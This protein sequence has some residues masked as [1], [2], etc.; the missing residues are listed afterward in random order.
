MGKSETLKRHGIDQF[1]DW[2][3]DLGFFAMWG[4][5]D[6]YEDGKEADDEWIEWVAEAACKTEEI[7]KLVCEAYADEETK[8]KVGTR[9]DVDFR[10]FL[11][12]IREDG[13]IAVFDADDPEE[14]LAI[15]FGTGKSIVRH[16]EEQGKAAIL[17]EPLEEGKTAEATAPDGNGTEGPETE[18]DERIETEFEEFVIW[19][20][21]MSHFVVVRDEEDA[22]S[23]VAACRTE[24]AAEIVRR[25]FE[26]RGLATR[27]A[28]SESF[29]WDGFICD[30]QVDACRAVFDAVRQEGSDD[31]E[32]IDGEGTP[33]VV[34][35]M[36]PPPIVRGV[37]DQGDEAF[38]VTFEDCF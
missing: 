27:M 14:P 30:L 9:Y 38:V 15:T 18:C 6:C 13:C 35:I 5:V 3:N 7:A 34:T 19:V 24:Q 22:W 10:N 31:L 21:E 37:R 20:D 8:V 28:T 33:L 1:E 17:E 26:K 12:K 32:P 25:H 29:D 16:L 23:T 11:G 2:A 36:D 4:E